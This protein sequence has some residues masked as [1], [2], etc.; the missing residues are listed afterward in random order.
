MSTHE[1]DD[2]TWARIEM[3]TALPDLIERAGRTAL[4]VERAL[5]PAREG[6]PVPACRHAAGAGGGLRGG[7]RTLAL[8][9]RHPDRLL[10]DPGGPVGRG[11]AREHADEDPPGCLVCGQS[12]EVPALTP[13]FAVVRLHEPLTVHTASDECSRYTG[14]LR[15][16]PVA[17]LC[18]RHAPLFPEP[19]VLD[20]PM[21]AGEPAAEDA[22]RRQRSP[23]RRR[24]RLRRGGR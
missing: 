3:A 22:P 6:S 4:A 15:T 7:V 17:H 14:E 21:P 12:T 5:A 20:W 10:C 18:P 8:C 9:L 13:V 1:T 16:L 19:W 11:C 23:S 24:R 2:Q